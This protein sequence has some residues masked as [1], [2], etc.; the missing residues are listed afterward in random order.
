MLLTLAG[1]GN[2]L[3]M[4]VM[5][6]VLAAMLISMLAAPFLI[7]HAEVIVRNMTPSAWMDSAMLDTPDRREKPWP[8]TRTSSSAVTGAAGRRC[9]VS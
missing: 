4:D 1:Q 2:L 3:P 6:N 5:Q 9:R 8:A 7:Q